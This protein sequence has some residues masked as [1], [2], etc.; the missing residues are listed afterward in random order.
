MSDDYSWTTGAED[1]IAHVKMIAAGGYGE[2]H[3]VY[4][5]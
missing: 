2:V 5:I 3:Q 4:L 1:G